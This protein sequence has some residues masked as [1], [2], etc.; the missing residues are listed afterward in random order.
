[1]LNNSTVNIVLY[2]PKPNKNVQLVSTAHVGTDICDTIFVMVIDFYNSERCGVDI[3]NQILRHYSYQPLC[4]SWVVV[5]FIFILDL[6]PVN[7]N[8]EILKC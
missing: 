8:F 5:V 4:D 7:A 6:A 3:I 2:W 1:M